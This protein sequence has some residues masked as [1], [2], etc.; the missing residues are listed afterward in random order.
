MSIDFS[1][2]F[3]LY[4][5]IT[6]PVTSYE[7]VAEAAVRAEVRFIQL[8][9]KHVARAEILERARTLRSITRGSRTLLIIND[10]PSIAV[11]SE[12]DGVHLGQGDQPL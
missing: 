12:A 11:E 7:T 1:Q 6:N 10:D 5:V 8:R 4:L 9:M 3:G 2:P